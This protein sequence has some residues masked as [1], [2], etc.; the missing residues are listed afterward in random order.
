MLNKRSSFAESRMGKKNPNWKGGITPQKRADARKRSREYYHKHR[1]ERKA[2]VRK[3]KEENPKKVRERSHRHYEKIKNNPEYKAR[4][5][6]Y[7]KWHNKTLGG[8]FVRYKSSAKNRGHK[9]TLTKKDFEKFWQQPCYYC[10]DEMETVGFDRVDS[11]KGYTSDNVAP[12]C[13][14][15]NRMKND[16]STQDFIEHCKKIINNLNKYGN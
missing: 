13:W 11:Q 5:K 16:D 8:I 10:G 6:A 4:I 7:N 15:C 2:Y 9:F 12:S 1:E 3:Y 14:R